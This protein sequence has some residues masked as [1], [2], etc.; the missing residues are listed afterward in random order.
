M[1]NPR[2]LL[3]GGVALVALAIVAGLSLTTG[4]SSD[5]RDRTPSILRA[6]LTLEKL[7]APGATA[8]ELLVSLADPELNTADVTGGA[9]VVSL[10]C[11]DDSGSVAIRRVV[12]WPLIEEPGYLPHIHQPASQRLL[13]SIRACRLTGP[14]IDFEGQ[15]PAAR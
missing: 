14:G 11:F 5:E 4:G 2:V 8:P 13:A 12:D 7:T 3:A 10:R 6:R 9:R 15:L 1:S